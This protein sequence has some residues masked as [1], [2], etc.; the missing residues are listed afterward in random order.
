M[1][2]YKLVHFDSLGYRERFALGS[3]TAID[4]VE[5][6]HELA[7]VHYVTEDGEH[8]SCALDLE[9]KTVVG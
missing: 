4:L 8:R 1:D 3:A 2:T 6:A 9:T 7:V 5:D